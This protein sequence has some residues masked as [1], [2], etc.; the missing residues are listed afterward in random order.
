[1]TSL[2]NLVNCRHKIISLR[3]ELILRDEITQ[4][5]NRFKDIDLSFLS[6]KTNNV[7]ILNHYNSLLELNSSLDQSLNNFIESL[8]RQIHEQGSILEQDSEYID[9]FNEYAWPIGTIDPYNTPTQ[10]YLSDIQQQLTQYTSWEYPGLQLYP[11][12]KQWTDVMLAS[13]PVYLIALR[14]HTLKPIIEHYPTLY[15]NR[16][17]LYSSN[18]FENII[19]RTLE[20]LPRNQFGHTVMWN[21]PLYLTS[22]YLEQ[23][24]KTIFDLLRP[25]GVCA[26][27]YN[28]CSI[29]ASAKL[30]ENKIFSFMTPQLIKDMCNRIGFDNVI[31]KDVALDDVT[32]T[33][34]SWVALYKP[35]TLS[36]M[37]SHQTLAQIIEK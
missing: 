24:L 2:S 20:F 10:Q 22:N 23:Y 18:D 30:A 6:D 11:Q 19:D 3:D 13:D 5:L 32:Y 27:N 35:G 8:D 26:F 4:R 33:H 1:M 31:F 34:V 28:N 21:T 9:K 25:G 7:E 14:K 15:Q 16:L 12:S 36:T 17:R 29:P 37:K